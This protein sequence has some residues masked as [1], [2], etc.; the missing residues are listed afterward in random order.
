MSNKQSLPSRTLIVME[1]G[2]KTEGKFGV[3]RNVH[4]CKWRDTLLRC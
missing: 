2:L 4:Q 1:G 3:G